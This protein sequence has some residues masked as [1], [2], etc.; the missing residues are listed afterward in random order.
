MDAMNTDRQQSAE[1]AMALDLCS[2]LTLVL[3]ERTVLDRILEIF[4]ALF[5]PEQMVFLIVEN[6]TVRTALTYPASLPAQT[7][8]RPD[9]LLTEPELTPDGF[10]LRIPYKNETIGVIEVKGLAFPAYRERY[11]SLAL[12]IAGVCG[13]AVSNARTHSRLET[14]LAG[15]RQEYTKSSQLSEE[16]RV[17][18]EELEARV[19]Q[20][21]ADLEDT[22]AR[23]KEEIVQR[24]AAEQDVQDALCY[25]RSVIEANPDL[26]AVLDRQGVVLDVNTAAETLTG[27]PR[28]QLIG[29]PYSRY[30]TDDSTPPDTLSRLQETGT[31]EYTVRLRRSDG[32]LTPLSVNSTL[33]RGKDASDTRIIVAAHDITRI[34]EAEETIQAALDEKVLLLREIH[35]RVKNNLQIIISLTNLQMRQ[36]DDPGVKQIM[37]ETQNRVRA[38]ALVHE[39][40]YRSDNLSRID[41]ADYSRFLAAQLFSY[42]GTDTRRIRL[43]FAMAKIMVDIVTAVPLGLLMNELVSNALKHAFPP[44]RGG[45]IRIHGEENGGLI[46]LVVRDD[47]IGIPADLDWQNTQSLGLRLVTSLVD[48]VDGT[49]GLDRSGGTAFTITMKRKT[50][51]GAAG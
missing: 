14:A 29:T 34:K 12:G 13:L 10:R 35:H 20:R 11:L 46:T 5:A 1:Y 44:G 2:Q 9:P 36:T 51:A 16:L 50:A 28:D 41:F 23:L 30:L 21:T 6:G 27:I 47:G 43:D 8:A 25:T 31:L 32:H 42:Y 45:T 22:M 48:Q 7:A 33:F 24:K 19:L 37:S 4:S 49:I 18:N 17:A 3:D 40:L 26:M 39:K 15:L 38:M